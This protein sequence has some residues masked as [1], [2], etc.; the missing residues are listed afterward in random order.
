MREEPNPASAEE[1]PEGSRESVNVDFPPGDDFRSTPELD[2][3]S[4]S[5][6]EPDIH[7]REIPPQD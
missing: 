3:K 6:P 5:G 4:D 2:G 7:G 1:Q